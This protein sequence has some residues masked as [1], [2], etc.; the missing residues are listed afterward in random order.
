[1]SGIPDAELKQTLASLP[2]RHMVGLLLRCVPQL[3]F[4]AGKPRPLEVWP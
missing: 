2:T 3:D 4:D 1:L